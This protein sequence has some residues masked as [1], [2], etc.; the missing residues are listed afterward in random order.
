MDDLR[1]S[2]DQLAA[3]R[4]ELDRTILELAQRIERLRIEA[5]A[6]VKL[7]SRDHEGERGPRPATNQ[8]REKT[9]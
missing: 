7:R 2:W 1:S 5:S 3:I 9:P 8:T 4:H 6:P